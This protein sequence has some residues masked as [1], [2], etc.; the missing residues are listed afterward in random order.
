MTGDQVE[1]GRL[2][3]THRATCALNADEHA[4]V[5]AAATADGRTVSG[6]LRRVVIGALAQQPDPEP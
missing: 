3:M 6:W 2:R 5:E 4:Q 1:Q